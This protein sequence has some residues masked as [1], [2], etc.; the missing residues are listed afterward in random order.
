MIGYEHIIKHQY[1]YILTDTKIELKLNNN[2]IY[3]FDD[4][5][6]ENWIISKDIIIILIQLQLILMKDSNFANFSCYFLQS[7]EL[8]SEKRKSINFCL[9]PKKGSGGREDEKDLYILVFRTFWNI[10]IFTQ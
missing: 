6:A 10:R 4:K 5:T 9:P 1:N 7:R 8:S 3:C 2:I